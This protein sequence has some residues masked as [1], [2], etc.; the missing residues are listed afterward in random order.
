TWDPLINSHLLYRLSYRGTSLPALLVASDTALQSPL[1]GAPFYGP[2]RA[3]QPRN[4]IQYRALRE[5]CSQPKRPRCT[6]PEPRLCQ[7]GKHDFLALHLAFRCCP[8]G[9]GAGEDLLRQRILDPA[10]DGALEG[11]RAVYRVVT[12]RHQLV[13][14]LVGQLQAQ[15]PLG[16]ALTQPR[17][18]DLRDAGDLLSGQWIEHHDLVDA[19]DEFRT[20]MVADRIHHRR[21]LCIGITH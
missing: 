14:C 4:S 7:S 9:E 12:D 15:L 10:L 17:K 19:I 20:E 16:Q 11:S 8:R 3:C 18:L 5:T 1:R 2:R 6:Q 13:H 21:A